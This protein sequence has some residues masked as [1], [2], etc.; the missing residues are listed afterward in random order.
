MAPRARGAAI[1][2]L[3]VIAERDRLSPVWDMSQEKA[4]TE[5]LLNQRFSFFSTYAR[6]L[7]SDF[8]FRASM[9]PGKTNR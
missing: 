1:D 7:D 6:G 2:S 3:A 4:L 5:T 8:T 9:R